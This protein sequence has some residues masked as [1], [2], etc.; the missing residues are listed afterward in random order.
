MD[1]WMIGIIF[2]MGIFF[3]SLPADMLQKGKAPISIDTP[4][5]ILVGKSAD[6][7]GK[8]LPKMGKIKLEII[9]P[10][11][12]NDTYTKTWTFNISVQDN[13][14]YK[15]SFKETKR[16]GKYNITVWAP[17]QK[18]SVK[19][20]LNVVNFSEMSNKMMEKSILLI[21]M[22]AKKIPLLEKKLVL[23]P[24]SPA[25][26]KAKERLEQIS[27]RLKEGK[28]QMEQ[29]KYALENVDTLVK[30]VP[31]I[32]KMLEPMYEKMGEYTQSLD[33]EHILLE[34]KFQR[35]A[36]RK[37]T[38]CDDVDMI[39]SGLEFVS[40]S[41]QSLLLMLSIPGKSMKG[42]LK[43]LGDK[44]LELTNKTGMENNKNLPGAKKSLPTSEIQMGKSVLITAIKSA[45]D[46][47]AWLKDS[48]DL[49]SSA[50]G[51]LA[52]KILGVYCEKYSGIFTA[53]LGAQYFAYDKK[54][55][56]YNITL[57]GKLNLR[58]EKSTGSGSV[59]V[60]G[61]F[62]GNAEKFQVW[63]DLMAA[64]PYMNRHVIFHLTLAPPPPLTAH[65]VVA[66]EFGKM[67]RYGLGPYAFLVPVHGLIDGDKIILEVD[68]AVKDY[69]SKIVRGLSLYILVEPSLPIPYVMRSDLPMV[70]AGFILSRGLRGKAIF[71]VKIDKKR[72][73]IEKVFHRTVKADNGEY[74][75]VWK[76]EVKAC[77][78]ECL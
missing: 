67:G 46:R 4:N 68:D 51:Y 11:Q 15:T 33:K 62:E 39:V 73:A 44:G 57:K 75:I 77:N 8:S 58:Y 7:S 32:G 18:S 71:D 72:S 27:S 28:P 21:D 30:K 45:G 41:M 76:V 25:T 37:P 40:G 34:E 66:N 31:Q 54:W 22:L 16:V 56:A 42:V 70:K 52:G 61:E 2:V 23:L 48:V 24:K 50:T 36:N 6:L 26:I 49:V 10:P 20:T 53:S 12:N 13:G 65:K 69:D 43:I 9:Y 14:D 64:T 19:K 60:S 78:P 35:L 38:R 55:W 5:L 47:K 3:S 1:R 74:K 29:F 59:R 17:D 63:D